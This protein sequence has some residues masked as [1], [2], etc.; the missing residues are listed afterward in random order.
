M[1]LARGTDGEYSDRTPMEIPRTDV[2]DRRPR[3]PSIRDTPTLERAIRKLEITTNETP[4]HLAHYRIVEQLGEGAMGVVYE[5]IDER[6]DRRVAVKLLRER[7]DEIAR[8]RFIGEARMLAH[9]SHPNVV[10]IHDIGEHEDQIFIVMEHIEGVD[11][12]SWLQLVPRSYTEILE[13]FIAAG[14]GLMAAHARGIVHRDFKPANVMIGVDGRIRVVD[15]GVARRDHMLETIDDCSEESDYSDFEG[16]TETGARV[17]T[18]AYMAPEQLRS[19]EA[20]PVTDQ[21]S[22]CVALWEA[23]YGVRPFVGSS[24]DVVL[25]KMDTGQFDVEEN[26]LAVP[27]WLRSALVRGLSADPQDRWPS[28]DMLLRALR[29]PTPRFFGVAKKLGS[30][31]L[32]LA[33]GLAAGRY[34]GTLAI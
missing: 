29:H 15:F 34:V 26:Q 5:A 8:L 3:S 21:F 33:G 18:P 20:L 24:V 25:D 11:L 2:L 27:S 17:G 6:L 32:L 9:L 13:V 31:L 28:M 30:V 23:L 22:F 16:L 4:S 1:N 19:E 7:S 14:Q 10:Q 12:A